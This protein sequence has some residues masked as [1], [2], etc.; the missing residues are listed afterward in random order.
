MTNNI[1]RNKSRKSYP[2]LTIAFAILFVQTLHA[3]GKEMGREFIFQ[4]APPVEAA[5]KQAVIKAHRKELLPA[6]RVRVKRSRSVTGSPVRH[7]HPELSSQQLVVVA[8]DNQGQEIARVLIPDPRVIRVEISDPSGKLSSEIIYRTQV[9]FPVV[10]PDDP[11]ISNFKIYQPRWTG[12]E[13]LLEL[14]DDGKLSVAN[15]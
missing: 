9:E 1:K 11:R 6:Y 7:R 4:L 8:V 3:A 2:F 15:K 13:F 12:T 14:I 5:G 10:I